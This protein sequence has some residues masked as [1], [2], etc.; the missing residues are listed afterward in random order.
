[1]KRR[2]LLF[3]GVQ[4]SIK[5]CNPVI[6]RDNHIQTGNH[7][8]GIWRSKTPAKFSDPV[9]RVRRAPLAENKIGESLQELFHRFIECC[10]TGVTAFDINKDSIGCPDPGNRGAAFFRIA[11]AKH[12]KQVLSY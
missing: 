2:L 5:R 11:F 7:W 6:A 10:V 4:E 1:M 3:P 9:K 12:V 8:G